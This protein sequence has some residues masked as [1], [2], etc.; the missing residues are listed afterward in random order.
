MDHFKARVFKNYIDLYVKKVESGKMMPIRPDRILVH[1][2]D[3]SYH[4][5]PPPLI[6]GGVTIVLVIAST[7]IILDL[8]DEERITFLVI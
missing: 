6:D 1:S 3:I 5:P 2:T 7:C 8:T 4:R